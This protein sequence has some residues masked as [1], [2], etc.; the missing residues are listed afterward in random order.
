MKKPW[1]KFFAFALILALL[2]GYFVPTNSVQAAGSISLTTLDT[3]YTQDFNTL[4]TTGTANTPVPTGWDLNET[5]TSSRNNGAY[6]ASNGSDNAGDV[7]SFGATGNTE[8]A[9]GSLQSGTLNPTIGASFTNNTGSNITALAITYTGE[10]WR[11]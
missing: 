11:L 2:S 4:A 8:R 3:A 5:G 7:Y 6:A 9:F 10:Q 1:L